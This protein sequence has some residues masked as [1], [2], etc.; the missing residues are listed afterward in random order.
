MIV[1]QVLDC[2][3]VKISKKQDNSSNDGQ[4]IAG[5]VG[6]PEVFSQLYK[7]HYDAVFRYCAHR[8]FD[9]HAAEDITS[10]VFFKVVE[11]I[12]NFKGT[13]TQFRNWLYTIATNAVN[14]YIRKKIRTDTLKTIFQQ[15]AEGTCKDCEVVERISDERLAILQKAVLELKPKYQ[16]IITLRF[17]ENLKLTEIAEVLSSRP[18]TVRSQLA[19]AL[20]KLRRKFGSSWQEV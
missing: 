16:T 6:D 17:F 8:L 20:L 11:H 12:D 1:I 9:R 4:L 2:R 13:E 7:R 14:N 18:S 19:R 15:K 3:E 10:E 5:Y